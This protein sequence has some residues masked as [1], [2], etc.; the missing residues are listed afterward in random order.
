MRRCPLAVTTR[1]PLQQHPGQQ[2]KATGGELREP[3]ATHSLRR[4][5]TEH[6]R[7]RP[8]SDTAGRGSWFLSRGEWRL[9][10]V[11]SLPLLSVPC[12]LSFRLQLFLFCLPLAVDTRHGSL[13]G[14]DPEVE[15]EMPSPVGSSAL[16]LAIAAPHAAA[17]FTTQASRGLRPPDSTAIIGTTPCR[18]HTACMCR[19]AFPLAVLLVVMRVSVTVRT[20]AH[21]WASLTN[22][23]PSS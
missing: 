14:F 15:N 6:G 10:L 13:L 16:A 17:P 3:R 20:H 8:W 2:R 5:R 12:F 7:F 11:F 23:G 19:G 22:K 18:G 1:L 9:A 4:I 21:A